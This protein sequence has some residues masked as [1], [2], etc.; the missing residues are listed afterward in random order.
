VVSLSRLARCAGL[1]VDQV[2]TGGAKE[3]FGDVSRWAWSEDLAVGL[4]FDFGSDVADPPSSLVPLTAQLLTDELAPNVFDLTGLN[5]SDRLYLERRRSIWEAGFDGG[6]L[7]VDPEGEPAYL[8]WLIPG[9]QHEKVREF[10]GPIF[11]DVSADTLVVE[12]AWVPPAF[13]KQKVMPAG[14]QAVTLAAGEANPDANFALCYPAAN[15]RGAV[16]GTRSS[17]Y[18]VVAK[19]TETWRIGRRSFTFEPSDES[20]FSVFDPR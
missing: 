5:S 9:H 6:W 18:A 20:G 8:Q 3:A 7:A 11:G 13:R 4:Q 16:L 14:L 12:G 1:L 19:R 2:R 17:G 15:N 10:F